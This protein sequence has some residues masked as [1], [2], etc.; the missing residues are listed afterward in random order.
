MKTVPDA[1]ETLAPR[2]IRASL[3]V[4]IAA[5]GAI[6]ILGSL[7]W[8]AAIFVTMPQSDSGFAE[9]LAIVVGGLY[10]VAGFVILSVGLLIPQHGTGGIRFSRGQRTR[11]AYG[12]AAPVVS[13]LLVPIGAAVAPPLTEPVTSVLVAVLGGL[14]L[15]GPLATLS[16]VVGTVKECCNSCER[17]E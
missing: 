6:V 3:Q 9:G 2:S 12:A 1:L 4:G 7:V 14:L 17:D 16:V 15:S 11:L 10:V 13:V 5:L 8:F